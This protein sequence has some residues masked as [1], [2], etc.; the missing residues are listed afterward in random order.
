VAYQNSRRACQYKQGGGGYPTVKDT[1]RPT[2]VN[3]ARSQPQ[4]ARPTRRWKHLGHTAK[5]RRRQSSL[6]TIMTAK[7]APP[8][9]LKW[10]AQCASSDFG[11]VTAVP[12]PNVLASPGRCHAVFQHTQR[13]SR[14]SASAFILILSVQHARRSSAYLLVSGSRPP[15]SSSPPSGSSF[16]LALFSLALRFMCGVWRK[17]L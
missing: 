1:H 16:F 3:G 13:P 15:A 12:W 17:T 11:A 2:I 4:F 9:R 5:V 8:S 14:Q 6:A 10:L 7:E